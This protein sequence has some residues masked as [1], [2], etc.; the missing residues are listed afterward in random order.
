MQKEA[1]DLVACFA[2]MPAL[3]WH[4]KGNADELRNVLTQNINMT[5]PNMH[6]YYAHAIKCS[7]TD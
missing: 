6:I 7:K 4:R 5:D 1:T 2:G 3:G